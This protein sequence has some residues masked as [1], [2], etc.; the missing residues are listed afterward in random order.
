MGRCFV[1]KDR[2]NK[3][4]GKCEPCLLITKNKAKNKPKRKRQREQ[5][6]K[7]DKVYR[8]KNREDIRR[9]ANW[10]NKKI[11]AVKKLKPAIDRIEKR[12]K[13]K[14]ML[15]DFINNHLMILQEKTN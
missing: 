6:R 13:T 2:I 10:R 14:D 7:Y 3:R 8:L 4:S 5:A 15:D 12:L 11:R 9:R 1:C